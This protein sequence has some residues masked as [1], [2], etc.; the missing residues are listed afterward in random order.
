VTK[1]TSI[2]RFQMRFVT[3]YPG[4][5]R[6]S[7]LSKPPTIIVSTLGIPRRG[8]TLADAEGLVGRPRRSRSRSGRRGRSGLLRAGRWATPTRSDPRE[9]ATE[10]RPP[11]PEPVRVK[12]WCKRPPAARATGPARQ[13]PPGARSNSARSRAARPSARVDRTRPPATAVPDGWSPN[14]T[15]QGVREQNPAYRPAPPPQVCV[16]APPR[17]QRRPAGG[18]RTRIQG[19]DRPAGQQ[20][21][22]DRTDNV[23]SP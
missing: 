17:H 5:P 6:W 12:R 1:R 7:S 16:R 3:D 10:N 23:R 11:A 22:V 18:P 21:T 2:G 9:S 14:G 15:P 8:P 13:T 4:K 19:L 20:C